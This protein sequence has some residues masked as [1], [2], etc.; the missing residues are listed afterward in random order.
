[1]RHATNSLRSNPTTVLRLYRGIAVP[2]SVLCSTIS[3]IKENGLTKGKGHWSGEQ[4]WGLPVDVLLEKVD[5]NLCDTRS[6]SVTR[7][8]IFASGTVESAA[9]YAWQHNRRSGNDTPIL[10]E[11]DAAFDRITID[12]KDF[13]YTVFQRGNPEKVRGVIEP[14]FGPKILTYAE[15]AWA[16]DDPDR[17]VALCDLAGLDPDAIAAHYANRIV[18]GGRYN[19]HFENAFTVALPVQPHAIVRVWSP[20]SRPAWRNASVTLADIL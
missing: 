14:L 15:A 8:A 3:S 4:S 10:V 13:L 2:A 11:F 16:S 18:I 19:T 1:M 12:G 20:K 6:E 7:P 9:Y 17:R 5:L